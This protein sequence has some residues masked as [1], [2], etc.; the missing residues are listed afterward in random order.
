MKTLRDRVERIFALM[1]ADYAAGKLEHAR[2][3]LSKAFHSPR[4]RPRGSELF[5]AL[6]TAINDHRPLIWK[7]GEGPTDWKG[8][9]SGRQ[10]HPSPVL[11]R[12]M[13]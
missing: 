9:K 1:E 6:W 13:T 4:A 3:R 5:M 11:T 8:P 10:L 7:L 2:G 12:E